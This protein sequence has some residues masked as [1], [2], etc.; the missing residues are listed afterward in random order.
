MKERYIYKSDVLV[1]YEEYYENGKL[2]SEI[3][4]ENNK[5]SGKAKYYHSN[6]SLRMETYFHNDIQRDTL[7][8]YYENGQ[9]QV[10]SFIA[11]GSK[12]GI[13][14]EYYESGKPKYKGELKDGYKDG[15]FKYYTPENKELSMFYNAGRLV[16]DQGDITKWRRQS[17]FGDSLELRLPKNWLLNRDMDNVVGFVDTLRKQDDFRG[18]ITI[19]KAD[20]PIELT[21]EQVIEQ[22]LSE[23]KADYPDVEI[24]ESEYGLIN[25]YQFYQLKYGMQVSGIEVKVLVTYYLIESSLYLVSCLGRASDFSEYLPFFQVISESVEVPDGISV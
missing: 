13:Y 2:L 10:L 15:N 11:N 4:I 3:P 17:L 6:G 5:K 16:Y 19:M 1:G 9:L 22:Q 25:D 12:T 23:M 8:V 18:S 21:F 7:K 24:G 20:Y 14:Q